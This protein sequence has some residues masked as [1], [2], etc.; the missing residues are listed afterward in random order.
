[1]TKKVVQLTLEPLR[2]RTRLASDWLSQSKITASSIVKVL[3]GEGFITIHSATDG[4]F[5]IRIDWHE[6]VVAIK[7]NSPDEEY[8]FFDLKAALTFVDAIVQ[9]SVHDFAQP[10][11]LDTAFLDALKCISQ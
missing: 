10:Q 3:I 9:S 11:S 8:H 1:M 2:R 6:Q 5:L 4:Q 7:T